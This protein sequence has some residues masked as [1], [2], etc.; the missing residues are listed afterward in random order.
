MEPLGELVEA[1][2]V[3]GDLKPDMLPRG[4]VAEELEA[5][6]QVSTRSVSK[7]VDSGR[8]VAGS[9][10]VPVLLGGKGGRVLVW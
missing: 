9:I 3:E 5:P 6:I 1:G 2:E 8:S 4:K 7:D 10:A